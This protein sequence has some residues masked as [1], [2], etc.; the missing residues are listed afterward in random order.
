[1]KPAQQRKP[2]A[3]TEFSSSENL[4]LWILNTKVFPFQTVM[5]AT[6]NSTLFPQKY[7]QI[8]NRHQIKIHFYYANT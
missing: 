8:K 6:Q 1:M 3:H 7:T 5:I 2:C 4:Y